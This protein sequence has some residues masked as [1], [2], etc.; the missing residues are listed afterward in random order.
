MLP[1]G[2]FPPPHVLTKPRRPDAEQRCAW[3]RTVDTSSTWHR[4]RHGRVT[5]SGGGVN[6]YPW[7]WLSFDVCL[8]RLRRNVWKLWS[9]QMWYIFWGHPVFSCMCNGATQ[10]VL[11][12]RFCLSPTMCQAFQLTG[13]RSFLKLHRIPI[14]PHV[15]P[16]L[17]PGGGVRW[18]AGHVFKNSFFVVMNSMN[19][20]QY[21]KKTCENSSTTQRKQQI[22]AIAHFFG[23]HAG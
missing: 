21:R 6:K 19:L 8:S 4:E 10:K 22:W 14:L 18:G 7:I 20:I 16:H 9:K 13:F 17:T 3:P 5:E 23:V 12:V 11:G 15:G 1:S 2:E